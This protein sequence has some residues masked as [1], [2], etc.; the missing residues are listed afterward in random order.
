MKHDQRE[1]V[2]VWAIF[3]LTLLALCLHSCATEGGS[4]VGEFITK[5]LHVDGFAQFLYGAIVA[6]VIGAVSGVA[7]VVA[8]LIGISSVAVTKATEPSAPPTTVVNNNGKGK[9]QLNTPNSSSGFLGIPSFWWGVIAVA[10]VLFVVRNRVHLMA[11]ATS[12]IPPGQRLRTAVG[13]L[14]GG[15]QQPPTTTPPPVAGQ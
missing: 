2:T 4:T 12:K 10:V 14:I 9:I 13:M 5:T 1:H 11:L 15:N 6:L 3:I 7:P 8:L